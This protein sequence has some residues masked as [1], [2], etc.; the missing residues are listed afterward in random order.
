[1][2]LGIK[3]IT[4]SVVEDD[5]SLIMLGK[6]S[7]D[8]VEFD[9]NKAVPVGAII[10]D[11]KT[12]GGKATLRVKSDENKQVRI[13]AH[14]TLAPLSIQHNELNKDSVITDKIKDLAVIDKKL[15]KDSVITVK[16]KDLAVTEP[17]LGPSSVTVS[18]I[19]N[20]A[21][22]E[23]KIYDS[24]VTTPKIKNDNVTRDKLSPA[25]RNELDGL[26]KS[27]TDLDN[28][29][30]SHVA[31]SDRKFEQLFNKVAQLEND[32][33]L[34]RAEMYTKLQELESKLK[35]EI[36]NTIEKYNLK[37]AVIHHNYDIMGDKDTAGKY[38]ST[39][40]SDIKCSGNIT[41]AGDINGKRVFFMTYQD[42]AEAYI[43]GE[44]LE[45]GDIVAIHNDGK[46]Y[47]AEAMNDC[48]VGVIS[49]EFANCLGA[50]KEELFNGSKV[51]VGMIGKVHVKVKGPVKL[52]QY[53][54]ISL[55]DSGVGCGLGM[56]VESKGIGKALEEY[57]C[58]FDEI[59]EV[60]V[61][62]R[63]M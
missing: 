26:R 30:K 51:A 47:K 33:R 14:T 10:S 12:T 27:I 37:N 3:K 11:A 5:R 18:K 1:M 63:P 41:C 17:K 7:G 58:D 25:L 6:L 56:A 31:E 38:T 22:T 23:P 44:A 49:N 55:S 62:I 46:V 28:R 8:K 2:A 43:P 57:D 13:D 34:L 16:I 40:L 4:E 9:D 48:V 20:G 39:P 24:A 52:G 50:S 42:L 35:T 19:M 32:I 21:V 36:N 45:A 53:I 29:F 60:L 54:G 59:H 61:Q 15:A